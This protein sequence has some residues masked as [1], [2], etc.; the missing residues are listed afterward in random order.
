MN[1]LKY[2]LLV[3]LFSSSV[4]MAAP[5]SDS[6][7]K[8]LLSVMHSRQLLD[9]MRSRVGGVMDN[10]AKQALGGKKPTAKQEKAIKRMK[11]RMVALMQKTLS[12]KKLEPV[13]IRLYKQSFTD[14]EVKGMLAFY[15][16]PTGQ[17][18]IKKMPG[19]IQQTM[20]E[21]QKMT[22]GMM[23]QMQKIQKDFLADMKKADK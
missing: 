13:Y 15:K 17:A 19:L 6:S 2:S 20:R 12:W 8:Q 10:A 11:S 1:I 23:P 16:T 5:A 9:G 14:Q 7:V 3:F 18:V 21:I 22:Y 4:A